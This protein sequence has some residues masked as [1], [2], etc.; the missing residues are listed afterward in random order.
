MEGIVLGCFSIKR[1]KVDFSSNQEQNLCFKFTILNLANN[2]S[3]IE[4]SIVDEPSIKVNL[5]EN[6]ISS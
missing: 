6:I 1:S 4:Y 5:Q 2:G 3:S